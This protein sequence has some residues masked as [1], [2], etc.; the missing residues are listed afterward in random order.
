MKPFTPEELEMICLIVGMV[1]FLYIICFYA[2]TQLDPDV[3]PGYLI[4]P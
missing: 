4:T 2:A 3:E 1:I